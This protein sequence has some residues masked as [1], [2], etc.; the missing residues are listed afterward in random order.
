MISCESCIGGNTTIN[1]AS[2]AWQLN[3][4]LAKPYI[5]AGLPPSS[6]GTG[7]TGGL[8]AATIDQRTGKVI[9]GATATLQDLSGASGETP[10][11]IQN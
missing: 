11:T 8:I 7:G 3:F 4:E 10:R 9:I 6:D 5:P 1:P 2:L